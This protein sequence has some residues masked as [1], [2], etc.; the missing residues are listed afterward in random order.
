MLLLALLAPLAATVLVLV[1]KSWR[2]SAI[3]ATGALLLS[4][5]LLLLAT[6]QRPLEEYPVEPALDLIILDGSGFNL[7][8][9][10]LASVICAAQAAVSP[11]YMQ[12]KARG[13]DPRLYYALLMISSAAMLATPLSGS[14]TSFFLLFEAYLL[15]TWLLLMLT[16]GHRAGGVANKY[17]LFTEAGALVTLLGLV[18]VYDRFGTF[19]FDRLSSVVTAPQEAAGLLALLLAAP[20]VKMCIF[21]L[22]IWLPDV[23]SVAPPSLIGIMVAAESVAGWSVARLL[24]VWPH[25]LDASGLFPPLV[26]LGTLT[27]IYGGLIALAQLDYRKLLAYTSIGGGGLLLVAAACSRSSL[28]GVAFLSLEHVLAKNA[29]LFTFGYFEEELEA[30]SVVQLGGLASSAPRSAVGALIAALSLAGM[31]PTVGFWADVTIL[32][33]VASSIGTG[34]E[35]IVLMLVIALA[36]VLFAAC[37]IWFFKRVFFGKPKVMLKEEWHCATA[38]SLLFSLLLVALGVYPTLVVELL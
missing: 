2:V 9:A 16:G 22:H 26:V 29:L 4:F 33:S 30:R 35:G 17:L 10:I 27:A 6:N 38:A 5:F 11:Y 20:L 3:V 7:L 19:R 34:P 32:A 37:S 8:F 24:L 13:V 18:L 15:S 21:P 12:R 1:F 25:A 14:L 31:P 23:Y 36:F 28:A